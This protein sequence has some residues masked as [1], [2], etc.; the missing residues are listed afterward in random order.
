MDLLCLYCCNGATL[1]YP[2][3]MK[4]Y[5]RIPAEVQAMRLPDDGPGQHDVC[6]WVEKEGGKL[7]FYDGLVE[8]NVKT[9]TGANWRWKQGALGGVYES[10]KIG[11][12]VVKDVCGNFRRYTNEEFIKHFNNS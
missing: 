3:L 10:V 4:T 1:K 12:W 7:T 8:H 2:N 9:T 11:E 6:C 5:K